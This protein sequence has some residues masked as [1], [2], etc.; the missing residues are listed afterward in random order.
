MSITLKLIVVSFLLSCLAIYL[1]GPPWFQ[2]GP[3]Q[4]P[5]SW[6]RAQFA[7]G[8]GWLAFGFVLLAFFRLWAGLP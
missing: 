2:F 8:A 7:H 4:H 6:L 3:R 1:Q 5:L